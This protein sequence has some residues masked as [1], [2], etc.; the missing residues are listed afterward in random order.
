MSIEILDYLIHKLTTTSV[1]MCDGTGLTPKLSQSSGNGIASVA[2]P[3][4]TC[5]QLLRFID[6][7]TVIDIREDSE[8]KSDDE[9]EYIKNLH[10]IPMGKVLSAVFLNSDEGK[11]IFKSGSKICF[12]CTRGGRALMTADWV[13]SNMNIE[14]HYLKGG[15]TEFLAVRDGK[16]VVDDDFLMILT[17]LEDDPE[18]TGV[19]LQLCVAAANKGK[20]VTLV[21]MHDATRLATKSYAKNNKLVC[22]E[23]LKPWNELLKTIIAKQGNIYCCNTCLRIRK[24]DDD[25]LID[26]AK[27][28]KGPNVIDMKEFCKMNFMM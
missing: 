6:D 19:G 8:R 27:R 4:I 2:A 26:E 11:N 20:T 24:I 10:F 28:V 16:I 7:F 1:N 14:A 9:K 17:H 21:L 15:L 22:P 5:R 18:K 13:Y 23:P 25:D 3:S 12:V